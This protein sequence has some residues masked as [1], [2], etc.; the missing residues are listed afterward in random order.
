MSSR[1]IRP[2][3]RSPLVADAIKDCSRRN[4]IV[5]DPFAGSGTILIAAER[6]GRRARALEIDPHYVD[7]AV[8]RWQDLHRQGRRSG[9]DR[10]D[11]SRRSTEERAVCSTRSTEPAPLPAIDDLRSSMGSLSRS[12]RAV[13]CR[14]IKR[15][16]RMPAVEQTTTATIAVGYRPASRRASVQTRQQGQ[17]ERP[18]E[19]DTQPEDRDPGG[20]V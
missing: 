15:P 17:P 1:C 9:R 2:S 18:R 5:L 10:P 14:T 7:V 11:V 13:N 16:R 6:T 8:K 3:S 12:D 19:R 20:A 4:G